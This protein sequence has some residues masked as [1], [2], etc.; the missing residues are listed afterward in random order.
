MVIKKK[1]KLSSKPSSRVT[2]KVPTF[3]VSQE[4]TQSKKKKKKSGAS[5]QANDQPSRTSAPVAL[6]RTMK[7]GG[8]RVTY[9]NSGTDGR[10]RVQHREYLCDVMGSTPFAVTPYNVNPGLSATF[11]WLS[12]I[13]RQYES[14][15]FRS[16]AFEYETQKS[17]ASDGVVMLTV[18]FDAADSA[19]L[20]KQQFM[21][22]HNSVRTSVWNECC[23]TADSSDL[24]KFGTQRYVRAVSTSPNEDIKTYDVGTL[25]V[26][27][28]GCVDTTAIGELYVSYDVELITPQNN[29][30]SDV[31]S[32]SAKVVGGGVVDYE[33]PFGDAA[34]LTGDL[35]ITATGRTLTFNKVGQYFVTFICQGTVLTNGPAITGTTY[36]ALPARG[37][38]NGI[39]ANA[40]NAFAHVSVDVR[41][42]GETVVFNMSGRATTIS[43]SYTWIGEGAYSL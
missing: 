25:F 24:H 9:S 33:N 39:F 1:M 43:S 19:P 8:P 27:T 40:G 12:R 20:D 42:V 32:N 15:L 30:N 38:T 10:I 17:T 35:P 28:Q 4:V 26:A 5:A 18:D 7:T 22:Y 23:F 21:S 6:T 11:T 3:S 2:L 16:L 36:A 29:P 34:V 37:K 13:A 31:L 14:Y 41:N